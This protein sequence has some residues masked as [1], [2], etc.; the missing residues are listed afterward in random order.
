M[1]GVQHCVRA[2]SDPFGQSEK[3]SS[4]SNGLNGLFGPQGG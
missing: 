2:G 1:A 3:Q 4:I